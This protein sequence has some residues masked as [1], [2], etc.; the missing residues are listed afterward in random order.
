MG[1]SNED[2]DAVLTCLKALPVEAF[3]GAPEDVL[4]LPVIEPEFVPVDPK[5]L[6]KTRSINSVKAA[7]LGPVNAEGTLVMNTDSFASLDESSL[8]EELET[9]ANMRTPKTTTTQYCHYGL[10]NTVH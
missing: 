2:V 10:M 1:C 6:L 9:F 7:T 3:S 5:H 4:L 8:K